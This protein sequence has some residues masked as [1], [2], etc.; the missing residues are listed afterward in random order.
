[1]RH[2]QVWRIGY[3]SSAVR[4]QTRESVSVSR[5]WLQPHVPQ[6]YPAAPGIRNQG[7]GERK[8]QRCFLPLGWYILGHRQDALRMQRPASRETRRDP[9]SAQWSCRRV[10]IGCCSVVGSAPCA[11]SMGN[12]SCL[13]FL[14]GVCRSQRGLLFRRQGPGW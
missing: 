5:L 14:R 11:L 2:R 7:S 3:R 4:E 1:M 13:R 10:R 12:A 9:M 6:K 8:A